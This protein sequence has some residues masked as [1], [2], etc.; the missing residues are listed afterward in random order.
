M[1]WFT[2]SPEARPWWHTAHMLSPEVPKLRTSPLG[3][4]TSASSIRPNS[5]SSV[6]QVRHAMPWLGSCAIW[7]PCSMK[8]GSP[9]AVWHVEQ[10]A[11]TE[12]SSS[13]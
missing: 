5:T 11:R 6:W 3:N 12:P 4:V 9:W 8:K 2:V 7:T 1:R 10:L 13:Q